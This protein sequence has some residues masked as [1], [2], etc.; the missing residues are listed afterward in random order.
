[1]NPHTRN[2]N[3]S[4]ETESFA[5]REQGILQR[6]KAL[7]SPNLTPSTTH[8]RKGTSG[9]QV[10]PEMQE[11]TSVGYQREQGEKREGVCESARA[12]LQ[13]CLA[14][15]VQNVWV[16]QLAVQ[17]A[18]HLL[19]V[20]SGRRPAQPV[21]GVDLFQQHVDTGGLRSPP[22]HPA[23]VSAGEPTGAGP[24]SPPAASPACNEAPGRTLPSGS[25]ARPPP[26]RPAPPP[27]RRWVERG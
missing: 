22:P 24:N 17:K 16:H 11:Q 20:S 6:W 5:I 13:R 18:A 8:L 26:S 19:H 15:A 12:H 4:R 14:K 23:A 2:K 7:P 3:F 1:M 21:A 27:V 10:S 9:S 25:R